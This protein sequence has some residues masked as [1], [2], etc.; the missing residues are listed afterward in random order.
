[1]MKQNTIFSDY[2]AAFSRCYPG[3]TVT[4][5]MA[6]DGGYWVL[7]NG[8]KGERPLTEKEITS[9]TRDFNRGYAVPAI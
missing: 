7:I 6:R 4:L 9:A 8:E 5:R 3:K 2:I 1:M